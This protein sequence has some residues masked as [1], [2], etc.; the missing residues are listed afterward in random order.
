MA[1]LG[2][3]KLFIK[4]SFFINDMND[5]YRKLS[6]SPNGRFLSSQVQWLQSAIRI[7]LHKKHVLEAKYFCFALYYLSKDKWLNAYQAISVVHVSFLKRSFKTWMCEI[8][9]RLSSLTPTNAQLCEIL[10]ISLVLII[11]IHVEM[12]S[13]SLQVL[14][15]LILN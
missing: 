5:R 8:I 2:P 4:S 13:V 7:S 14:Q 10:N 15:E 12:C 11:V 1:F 3:C 6:M 9:L